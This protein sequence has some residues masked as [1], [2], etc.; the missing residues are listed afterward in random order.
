M[1][2]VDYCLNTEIFTLQMYCFLL[3]NH[4]NAPTVLIG[5]SLG[6]LAKQDHWFG[7]NRSDQLLLV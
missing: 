5:L 2:I 6:L 1:G 3:K 4:Y 7:E